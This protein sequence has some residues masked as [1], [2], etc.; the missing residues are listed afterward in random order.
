MNK[1]RQE[2]GYRV[3][4]AGKENDIAIAGAGEI[5]KLNRKTT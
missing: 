4:Q 3:Q 2:P 5:V 1:S